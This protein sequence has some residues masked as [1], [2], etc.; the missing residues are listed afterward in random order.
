MRTEV[1]KPKLEFRIISKGN[2]SYYY[3]KDNGKWLLKKVYGV[4]DKKT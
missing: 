1:N 2:R 3:E 4:V